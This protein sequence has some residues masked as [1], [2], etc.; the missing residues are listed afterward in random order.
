MNEKQEKYKRDLIAACIKNRQE[1]A[2]NAKDA[3][4][5]I[6]QQ[7]NEYGQP[8]DRDDSFRAQLLRKRD[9][10]AEQYQKALDDITL[11]E[12]INPGIYCKNVSFGAVVVVS[13]Q[14][15][16]VANGMGKLSFENENV[17]VISPQVPVYKKIE[18][19]EKGDEYELNGR[20]MKIQD[21]F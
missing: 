7:A 13:G 21:L 17:F 19:L 4:R 8:R 16:F 10:Y 6:Q 9:L 12:K 2:N 18:G 1:M 20:K 15:M 3:M 11:L 5:D 14:K